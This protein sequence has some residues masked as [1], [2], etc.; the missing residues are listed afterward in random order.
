VIVENLKILFL[1]SQSR[2]LVFFSNAKLS[3]V[4]RYS[5]TA[6]IKEYREVIS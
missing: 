3:M 5:G 1:G 6:N 2:G 4:A